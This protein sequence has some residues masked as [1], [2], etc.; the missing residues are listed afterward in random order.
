MPAFAD[1]HTAALATV[2]SSKIAIA[3][4]NVPA[5]N[6][7]EKLVGEMLTEEGIMNSSKLVV[8]RLTPYSPVLNPIESC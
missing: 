5:L 3:T 6:G 4:D 8:L 1:L 7:V 2:S